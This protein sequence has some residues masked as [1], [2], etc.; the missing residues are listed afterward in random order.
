MKWK[1]SSFLPSHLSIKLRNT[2][3]TSNRQISTTIDG[4]MANFRYRSS[5]LGTRGWLA[6][7]LSLLDFFRFRQQISIK[8]WFSCNVLIY[9]LGPLFLSSFSVTIFSLFL[10]LYICISLCISLFLSKYISVSLSFSLYISFSLSFSFSLSLFLSL[11]FSYSLSLSRCANVWKFS[12]L[13]Y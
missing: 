6:R 1:T 10:S 7:T 4:C 12:S 3:Q 9:V 11:S 13:F 8:F 5:A 2:G